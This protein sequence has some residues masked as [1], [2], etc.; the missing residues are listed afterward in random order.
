MRWTNRFAPA[1]VSEWCQNAP[2][3]HVALPNYVGALPEAASYSWWR[4]LVSAGRVRTAVRRLCATHAIVV[5]EPGI[6]PLPV[7][8]WTAGQ[9]EADRHFRESLLQELL[10]IGGKAV[11]TMRQRWAPDARAVSATA[12]LG[13]PLMP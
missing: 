4:I 12:P 8:T 5:V 9:P 7:L 10:R 6:F 2:R 11:A 1:M 13:G 3:N